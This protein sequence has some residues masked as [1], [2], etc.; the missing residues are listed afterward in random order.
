MCEDFG[1]VPLQTHAHTAQTDPRKQALY[2]YRLR[3]RFAV[4]GRK[5]Q[6]GWKEEEGVAWRERV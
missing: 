4:R 5:R 2:K 6:D 3:F 1:L